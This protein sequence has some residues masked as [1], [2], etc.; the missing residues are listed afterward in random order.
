MRKTG[1]TQKKAVRWVAGVVALALMILWSGGIFDRKLS[2]GQAQGVKGLLLPENA[3][4]V[5]AVVEDVAPMID[6]A[7]TVEAE[8]LIHLSARIS[9]YVDQ[10]FVSAGDPVKKG[11]VLITLDDREVRKQQEIA[12]ADFVQ[13][14]VEFNRTRELL[15]GNAATEQQMT[16]AKANDARAKAALERMNVMLSYAQII[17]PID[18]IVTD[19]RIEA[20]DLANPGEILL[21][22][23]DTQRMRIVVPVPVRLAGKLKIGGKALIT[24]DGYGDAQGTVTEVV[25]E[26]DPSSRTQQV[27][28]HLE[29][30]EQP[31]LPGT[32]G[33]VWVHDDARKS[34]MIPA[35]CVYPVGQL[36]LVQTVED[37]RVMRRLVKTGPTAGDAVEILSGL[38]GGE[39]VLLQPIRQ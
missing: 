8:E 34:V 29:P 13:A 31:V 39:T 18:G 27:R 17:S 10:V 14:E 26:I 21:S 11:E 16:S 33:R 28:I 32:F 6:I 19:R 24:M 30:V 7:G 22:V 36:E 5:T 4:T 9:A 15:K 25:R 2:E 37:G 38:A 1:W 23:Y 35:S 20:G 3:Q 12:D